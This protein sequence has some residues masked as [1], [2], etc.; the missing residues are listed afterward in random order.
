MFLIE[1]RSDLPDVTYTPRLNPL[2]HPVV[3]VALDATVGRR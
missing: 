1:D 3:V 2:P